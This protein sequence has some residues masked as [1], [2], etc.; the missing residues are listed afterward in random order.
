MPLDF[1]ALQSKLNDM[2][3]CDFL[4]N[5]SLVRFLD[6]RF[7]QDVWFWGI[8]LVIYFYNASVFQSYIQLQLILR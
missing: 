1:C 7:L 6:Y 8:C 5:K 3:I 4:F 2:V